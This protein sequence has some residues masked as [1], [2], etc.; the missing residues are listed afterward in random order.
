MNRRIVH[1]FS[2]LIL[3][4]IVR[5]ESAASDTP[6]LVSFRVTP[7]TFKINRINLFKFTF[8]FRDDGKNLLGGY[9]CWNI[10][11]EKKS[12]GAP[13]IRLVRPAGLKPGASPLSGGPL[14]DYFAHPF[15]YSVFSNATGSFSF[16]ASFLAENCDT[17]RFEAP[18]I[19]DKAGNVSADG[20]DV[21]LT[22]ETGPAGEKQ[23]Y[24]VG[25][26]AYDFTL[27]DKDKR[28]VTLTNYRGKVV[29]IDFSTMY[30]PA[31][32][33]EGRHLEQLY[34][35]YKAQGL[36]ILSA[37]SLDDYKNVPTFVDLK[38]W[39]SRN[40]MTF[41]V[42]GDPH[43]AVHKIY[44]GFAS[45]LSIPYNIVIDRLGKIAL[46]VAGYTSAI[47]TQLENKI[48]SLL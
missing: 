8:Q 41:P 2:I 31:C 28:R 7:T 1:L 11:Y 17:I 39:A 30:C 36:I 23:G 5:A 13:A 43:Y 20:P 15:D 42:I 14:P 37:I 27:F 24:K 32:Q 18:R 21:I 12:G 19:R 10:V 3:A 47:H 35:A 22:R 4:S 48:K 40:R 16:Y 34:Q 46:K 9:I 44:T 29:L 33:E 26:K 25:Q 6:A 45:S 38:L